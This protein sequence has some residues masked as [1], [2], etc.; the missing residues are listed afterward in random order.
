MWKKVRNRNDHLNRAIKFTGDAIE[1]GRWMMRVLSEWPISC[2]HNLSGNWQNRRA[3]IGH[4]ACAIAIKCPEDIVREA[5][6][7]LTEEQQIAAN[8]KAD[9]AIKEWECR[10]THL[11]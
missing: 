10:N 3:W 9:L 11:V 8:A 7:H 4:A 6:G 1:Y 5:W 2:E